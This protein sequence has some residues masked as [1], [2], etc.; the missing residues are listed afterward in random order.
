LSYKLIFARNFTKEFDKLPKSIK[1]QLLKSLGK[2]VD[3][4]YAGSCG[5]S[6]T[7]YGDCG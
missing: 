7:D 2:A 6:L 4:P 1:E 5:A 3:S